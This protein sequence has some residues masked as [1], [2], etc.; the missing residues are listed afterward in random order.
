MV[1]ISLPDLASAYG[2]DLSTMSLAYVADTA[3]RIV[4]AA[5]LGG[6]CLGPF[7]SG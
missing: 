4:M 2:T 6:E 5:L 3:G 1:F 7:T